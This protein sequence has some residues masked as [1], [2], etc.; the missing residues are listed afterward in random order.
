[1]EE[2]F[3]VSD[4]QLR[5]LGAAWGIVDEFYDMFGNCRRTSRESYE[6]LLTAL[7]C[8][9]VHP[10][11]PPPSPVLIMLHGSTLATPG[12]GELI[13]EDGAVLRIENHFPSDLPIGYH[14]FR[15]HENDARR[16]LIVRPQQCVLPPGLKIWGWSAQLYATRSERSWGIGDLGDLQRLARWSRELGAGMVMLNPLCAATPTIPQQASPYYPSSRCFRNPLYIDI[17]QAPGA[18]EA[19]LDLEPLAGAGRAL[20]E[21]PLIDRDAV[22][23]L[24]MEALEKLWRRQGDISE[25]ERYRRERGDVLTT[26]ARFCVL[27]EHLGPNWRKWPAEFRRPDSPAVSR[28][29]EEQA[30]RVQFHEWLQ[31]ILDQQLARANVELPLVNDLPIGVDPGGADAWAW[32]DVLA[33]NVRVGAPPDHFNMSGQDWGL[34]PFSPVQLQAAE[35]RPFIEILRTTF[36]HAG[37]VRIDHVMGLFRMYWIPVGWGADRGTYVRYPA[38]EFLA[39]LAVESHRAGAWVAG[40]DLGTV[41]PGVRERLAAESIL[42]H[43]LLWFESA[44]PATYPWRSIAAIT[45]HDL[46][47]VAGLWSGA[48]VA[49]QRSLGMTPDEQGYRQIQKNVQGM[50]NLGDDA[51]MDEIIVAAHRLLAQAPSAV[52]VGALTDALAVAERPNMPGTIDTWP[53]WSQALPLPLEKIE[54]HELCRRVAEALAR[55]N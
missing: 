51:P 15:L 35:Y 29:A 1:M 20:N 26:F 11:A 4:E 13:L 17:S 33:L 7:G 53:N 18:S 27:A 34:P 38:D 43:R 16:L 45:T 36:Q 12:P 39:I 40:E 46:P 48:D 32:Q 10:V 5:A 52:I 44:P 22:F 23:R 55:P 47:T 14:T 24:K 2:T 50:A 25:L 3:A 54:N 49:A 41:E 42:S 9:P 37:G 30:D 28:F 31:W 6:T 21:A 8:D 19:S